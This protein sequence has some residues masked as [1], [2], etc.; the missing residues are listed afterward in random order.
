MKKKLSVFLLF[1]I[2]A[3]GVFTFSNN[4]Y[5]VNQMKELKDD[6]Y[7]TGV[8]TLTVLD[9]QDVSYLTTK[10]TEVTEVIYADFH[11][12]QEHEFIEFTKEIDG[13]LYK[14]T[15]RLYRGVKQEDGSWKVTYSGVISKVESS[16]E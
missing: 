7:S 10:E 16:N 8:Q 3:C 14:G 1:T 9:S 5:A 2:L 12:V 11:E 15:L 13:H 6:N 4:S